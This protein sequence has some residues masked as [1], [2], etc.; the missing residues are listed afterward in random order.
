MLGLGRTSVVYYHIRKNTDSIAISVICEP[1][2]LCYELI[3]WVIQVPQKGLDGWIAHV[4][5][6]CHKLCPKSKEYIPAFMELGPT[7]RV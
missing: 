1:Y 7:H 5:E 6:V 3:E 2:Y 4:K